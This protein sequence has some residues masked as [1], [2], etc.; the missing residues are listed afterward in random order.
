MNSENYYEERQVLIDGVCKKFQLFIPRVS[1]PELAKLPTILFL[2]GSGE[3]GSDNRSQLLEG[4]PYWLQ[5]RP[6]F[7]A[8]VVVP[9]A[10]RN[11]S[12]TQSSQLRVALAALT[13]TIKEFGSKRGG[14][15]LT[16][17]SDG[18]IGSWKLAYEVPSKFAAIVTVCG[19]IHYAKNGRRHLIDCKP[20]LRGLENPYLSVARR[21]SDLKI[22]MFHG[23]LDDTVPIDESQ[24][25]FEAFRSI[26]VPARYTELRNAG[27]RCWDLAYATH[28]LWEW[29]LT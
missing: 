21:L 17:I 13:S 29:L 11:A 2:H 26:G 27:H 5:T 8:L 10:E 25:M 22:W 6:N 1:K 24:K 20:S 18:A 19:A 15:Y 16:G 28:D 4:L 3:R 7:P 14:T 23:N 12:W 9:Q